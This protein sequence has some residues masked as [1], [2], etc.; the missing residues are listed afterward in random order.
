MSDEWLSCDLPRAFRLSLV[1]RHWS[2]PLLALLVASL[3]AHAAGQPPVTFS[4]TAALKHATA[5]ADIGPRVPGTPGHEK[6]E[7]YIL[8]ELEALSLKPEVDAF[9]AATPLGPR[10]MRNIVMRFPGQSDRVVMV[11]GHYDTKYFTHF[12]FVGANDG[13]SSAALLLELARVLKKSPQGPLSVWLAFLDGEEAFGEWTATDSLYGSR[14]L[15]ERLRASGERRKLDAFILVDMIGDRNLDLL[16]DLN[17]T[18]WLNE[19]VREVAAAQGLSR[20]FGN[21]QTAIEDDHMPFAGMGVPVVD[22]ID[23]NYGPDN[24]FWH[25]AEDTPDKLSARSLQAV[26][27]IVLGTIDALAKRK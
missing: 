2:L 27:R 20:V 1:T 6:A 15:A 7:R 25:T 3:V 16:R 23:F 4:G 8:K 21:F 24:S 22:L 18:G 19:M 11:G 12:R 26:G 13:G 9:T 5:L 14:H 10:P 17:S